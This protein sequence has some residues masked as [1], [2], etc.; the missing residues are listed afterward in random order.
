MIYPRK[1]A[2]TYG[3][4]AEIEGQYAVG[5]QVVVINVETPTKLSS[6]QR[7]LFEQLGKSLGH[8]VLPQEKGFLDW[9]NEALGG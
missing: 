4:K 8:E 2:K 3:T 6:E 5:D 9:L 1:E 7:K